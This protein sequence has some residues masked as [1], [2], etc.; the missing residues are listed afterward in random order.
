VKGKK[1]EG[2]LLLH[3]YPIAGKRRE[4][5][6]ATSSIR[7]VRASSR[8]S[9]AAAEKKEGREGEASLSDIIEAGKETR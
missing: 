8:L 9:Y 3:P 4:R 1:K 5:R 6:R 7:A 2:V